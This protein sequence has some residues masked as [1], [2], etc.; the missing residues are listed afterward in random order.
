M[1]PPNTRKSR[2]AYT[3]GTEYDFYPDFICWKPKSKWNLMKFDFLKTQE[4]DLNWCILTARNTPTSGPCTSGILQFKTPKPPS[5]IPESLPSLSLHPIPWEETLNTRNNLISYWNRP[6][7]SLL[8]PN[9]GILWIAPKQNPDQAV[10]FPPSSSPH[11]LHLGS[12]IASAE[13]IFAGVITDPTLLPLPLTLSCGNLLR[14]CNPEEEYITCITAALQNLAPRSRMASRDNHQE[15][16]TL[17]CSRRV[18]PQRTNQT[19]LETDLT[20]HELPPLPF[21]QRSVNPTLIMG[22]VRTES[23]MPIQR[24]HSPGAVEVTGFP[25]RLFL[26]KHIY[27]SITIPSRD[28]NEQLAFLRHCRYLQQGHPSYGITHTLMQLHLLTPSPAVFI[29]FL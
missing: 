6:T 8:V 17:R 23:P 27:L 16:P 25:P 4:N 7:T 20:Q 2:K 9:T 22:S 14:S 19:V 24:T 18:V 12:Q 1:C 29:G 10:P 28:R 11:H 3:T 13:S 5:S 21:I 26:P 15:G